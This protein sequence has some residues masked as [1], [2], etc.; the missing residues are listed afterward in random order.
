MFS[1]KIY[2]RIKKKGRGWVFCSKYFYDISDRT[3]V[4]KT[5]S[6]LAKNNIIE[7]I[8]HGLYYYPE[9]SKILSSSV[10]PRHG[11][12]AKVY[13]DSIGMNIMHHGAEAAN[14][15]DLSLQVPAK[16]Y[17]ICDKKAMVKKFGK[18]ELYFKSSYLAKIK[19]LP[20]KVSLILSA[21]D[22]LGKEYINEDKIRKCAKILN[23]T[24]RKTLLK[25]SDSLSYWLRD[26]VRKIA[27][28]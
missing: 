14:M 2:N 25:I 22:Y 16:P 17:Y 6:N 10:P 4:R 26:V 24:E 11:D 19:G 15:L 13:A 8:S 7:R 21:L 20:L 3:N 28:L 12:I 23:Y 18:T 27:L 1:D 9:Y 5:L